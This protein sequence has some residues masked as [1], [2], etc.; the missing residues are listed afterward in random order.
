MHAGWTHHLELKVAAQA[1]C[2]LMSVGETLG[3]MRDMATT[4]SSRMTGS[5]EGSCTHP[6]WGMVLVQG[7]IADRGTKKSIKWWAP[8]R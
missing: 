7:G 8:R 1:S 3:L 6:A 5:L 4:K 2:F